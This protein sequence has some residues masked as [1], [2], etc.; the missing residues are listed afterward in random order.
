M[1]RHNEPFG[2]DAQFNLI[3]ETA[4]LNQGLGNS[5]A[6]RVADAG[7]FSFHVLLSNYIVITWDWASRACFENGRFEKARL[8][9][10]PVLAAKRCGL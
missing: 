3:A 2:S 6:S 7:E 9:S 5:N 1:G 4:L 10:V 8:L